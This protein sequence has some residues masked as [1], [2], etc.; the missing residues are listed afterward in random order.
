MRALSSEDTTDLRSQC[1]FTLSN[2]A[3]GEINGSASRARDTSGCDR[4]AVHPAKLATTR[5]PTQ[6][7]L[8]NAIL[9]NAF[10]T[11]ASVAKWI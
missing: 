10:P 3:G 11:V 7:I 4:G 8:T 9:T 1:G 6:T 2:V 5:T